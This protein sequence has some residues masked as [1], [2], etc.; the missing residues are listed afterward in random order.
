MLNFHVFQLPEV[1]GSATVQESV[2][3]GQVATIDCTKSSFLGIDEVCLLL[4]HDVHIVVTSP[5]RPSHCRL[6]E[7]GRL[8]REGISLQQHAR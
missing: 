5:S 1:V 7:L 8:A 2:E 4:N 3:R 6:P